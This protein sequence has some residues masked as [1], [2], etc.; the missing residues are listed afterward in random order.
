MPKT[1]KNTEKHPR[2][3]LENKIN[4]FMSWFKRFCITHWIRNHIWT[5]KSPQENIF[6]G[7]QS[8]YDCPYL[9]LIYQKGL[10]LELNIGTM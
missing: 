9:V 4:F 10:G 8:I 5:K 7:I 2:T 3:T 6:L 1:D